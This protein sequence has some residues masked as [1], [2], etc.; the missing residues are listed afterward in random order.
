MPLADSGRLVIGTWW[1][2]VLVVVTTYCGNLVAFLTF[3][4]VDKL[5]TDIHDLLERKDTLTWGIHDSSY[6]KTLLM[7]SF[8]ENTFN[9]I[10]KNIFIY[11]K[12]KCC[13]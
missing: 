4:K 8:L 11:I 10:V 6:I 13:R 9:N 7:V 12:L 3:P 1:I 5:I 2:V